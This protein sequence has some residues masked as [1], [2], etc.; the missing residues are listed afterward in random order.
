[1]K[2]FSCFHQ[3]MDLAYSQAELRERIKVTVS[4]SICDIL[5]DLHV[6]GF[7]AQKTKRRCRVSSQSIW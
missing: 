5:Q 7:E 2:A 6:L 3:A 4:T 1:M